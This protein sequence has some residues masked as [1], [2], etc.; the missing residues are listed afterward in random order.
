MDRPPGKK[1]PSRD[2]PPVKETTP[3]TPPVKAEPARITTLQPSDDTSGSAETKP[4]SDAP[5]RQATRPGK[6]TGAG[7]KVFAKD[8]KS[9]DSMTKIPITLLDRLMNLATELVVVRNENMEAVNSRDLNWLLGEL[10]KPVHGIKY[11]NPEKVD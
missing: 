4:S 5:G 6:G 10:K 2:K 1:A 7:K 11:I 8:R 3:K 9:T